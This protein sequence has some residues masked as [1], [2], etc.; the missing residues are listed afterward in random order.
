M[1]QGVET[2]RIAYEI[3]K[4]KKQGKAKYEPED[5]FPHDCESYR[6]YDVMDVYLDSLPKNRPI[7]M[8][9]IGCGFGMEPRRIVR[10]NP[11]ISVLAT[12]ITPGFIEVGQTINEMC[13]MT[14]QIEM[15]VMDCQSPEL[16]D[17]GPFDTVLSTGVF[18][19][20]REKEKLLRRLNKILSVG[21]LVYIDDYIVSPGYQLTADEQGALDEMSFSGYITP[22]QYITA[23]ENAGYRVL[24]Y[25]DKTKNSTDTE[26][27][28]AN[29][30]LA[31]KEEILS[32]GEDTWTG[33]PKFIVEKLAITLLHETDLDKE[34][35]RE[36]YPLFYELRGHELDEWLGKM[37]NLVYGCFIVV[38]VRDVEVE[39]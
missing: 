14:D 24:Q 12:D 17:L 8:L 6:N 26:F 33:W 20:I 5:F 18:L 22:G 1:S 15:K 38:K 28:F 10:R 23:F 30:F 13:Q 16:F 9:D 25:R 7:R 34:T 21:S 3:E 27:W 4:I 19:F 32:L 35:I 2:R 37:Q 31:S 11:N 29:R 39:E 36:K